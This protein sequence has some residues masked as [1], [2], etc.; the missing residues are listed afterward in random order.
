MG[1]AGN[2]GGLLFRTNS[3]CRRAT[4]LPAS[5]RPSEESHSGG[6]RVEVRRNPRTPRRFRLE[7]S[8][9]G[10]RAE[11]FPPSHRSITAAVCWEEWWWG[12]GRRRGEGGVN[13]MCPGTKAIGG[14]G[15]RGWGG[16]KDACSGGCNHS[17]GGAEGTRRPVCLVAGGEGGG[18]LIFGVIAHLPVSNQRTNGSICMTGFARRRNRVSAPIKDPAG[19][20]S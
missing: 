6:V 3:A 17:G 20:P 12:G 10:R 16:G 4:R 9:V 13:L 8:H 7:L 14:G 2:T 15:G 5:G 1:G 19:A 11:R 18:R